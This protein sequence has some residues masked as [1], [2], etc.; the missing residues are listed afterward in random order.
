[1]ASATHDLYDYLPRPLTGTNFYCLV[2]RGTYMC[3]QLTQSRYVK[4]SGRDSNCDLSVATC[5]SDAPNCTA[6]AVFCHRGAPGTHLRPASLIDAHF[7]E[8]SLLFPLPYPI[9]SHLSFFHLSP[10]P[11]FSPSAYQFDPPSLTILLLSQGP[12]I[13]SSY[14][15]FGVSSPSRSRRSP[16]AK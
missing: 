2:N 11:P 5:K 6:T 14:R 9:S 13:K 12:P 7:N 4:L 1:M 15:G 3:E 10:L 16:A 8:T